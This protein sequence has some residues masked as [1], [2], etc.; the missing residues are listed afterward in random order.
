MNYLWSKAMPESGEKRFCFSTQELS[1]HT[2]GH[3]P[4]FSPAAAGWVVKTWQFAVEMSEIG[5]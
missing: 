2:G 4:M 1:R 3:D 5:S